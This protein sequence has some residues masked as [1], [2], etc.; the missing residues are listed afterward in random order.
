MKLDS[1]TAV[2]LCEGFLEAESEEQVIAAW[3][4][5]HDTGMAYT[6]QGWFGRQATALLEAGVIVDKRGKQNG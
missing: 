6:L 3:Q 4:Y 1:Y 5:L 2:G